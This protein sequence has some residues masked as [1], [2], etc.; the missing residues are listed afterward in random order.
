MHVGH[1]KDIRAP[2]LARGVM[3]RA[4]T[5]RCSK[6]LL[7]ISERARLGEIQIVKVPS[8]SR[9]HVKEFT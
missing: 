2:H 5:L 4:L 1:E 9:L 3:I 7:R 6:R 8:F